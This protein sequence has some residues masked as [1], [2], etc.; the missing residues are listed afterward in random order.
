[1]INPSERDVI[2]KERVPPSPPSVRLLI[3]DD[4]PISSGILL[5]TVRHW[6]FETMPASDGAE[7][8]RLL[9]DP[10]I[11]LAILDWEMP[12]ANGPDLCRR[13]RDNP[14]KLYTYIILLT[15]RDNQEDIIAGLEA[16]ADDYMTK[17]VK[18]QELRARLQT[19]RRVI[20]LE[21][22]LLDNQKRLYDLATKDGL[23]KLW[24]RRT[25]LQFLSDE[26]A[27]AERTDAPASAIM[28]DVDH[29]KTIN[30]T[31]GHQAGDKV[32]VT[33]ARRL[34]QHV[35]PYDRIGR[36][37]G[38]EILIVLPNCGAKD[39]VIIA[40]RLR[41]GCIRKPARHYGRPLGFTLS[42]GVASTEGC[43]NPTVDRLIQA[44]DQALYEAKR[45]GR[46]RVVKAERKPARRKGP[47]RNVRKK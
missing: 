42:I 4:D 25:I 6:G 33:L 38:D 11:R 5:R 2:E 14:K 17:P 20:D 18:L 7:A 28:I 39:A 35:R 21:D 3:A 43:R 16:G 15:S 10:G 13:I 40:E 12:E 27:Y 19:G 32:L 1:V 46:D 34:K 36:Y 41:K 9:Q 44:G 29:F 31:C 8:W 22:K 37:G 24:N 30:D 45:M 23:T 26:L 47:A